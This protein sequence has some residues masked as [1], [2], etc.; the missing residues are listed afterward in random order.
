MIDGARL[1]E[2][3][4]LSSSVETVQQDWDD[5]VGEV[6]A[7]GAIVEEYL[8]GR[9]CSP[10]GQAYIDRAGEVHVLST[11]EQYTVVDQYLGC[12]FP[13]DDCF[14]PGIHGALVKVGRKLA[15]NGVR[16]TFGVDFISL[17][18]GSLLA[19]EINL[20]KV[21]PSHA[22]AYAEA[23]AGRKVGPDG[24][25]RV[26]GEP[27]YFSHRRVHQPQVLRGLSPQAAVQ[28]LV[29]DGLSYDPA[30]GKGTLLHILGALGPLGYV[31]TTCLGRSRREA[32]DASD[33]AF[34]SLVRTATSRG[35]RLGHATADDA[36][37]LH[38]VIDLDQLEP[39]GLP[40][41]RVRRQ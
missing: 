39:E 18:D 34:A 24:N 11:H 1:R 4:D 36:T 9:I 35:R 15:A 7:G 16:G 30:S 8:A 33:A 22:V 28:G 6:G 10:S 25:L 13:A 27:L 40:S 32:A 37:L 12:E 14:R 19:T 3:S 5:I 23:V 17:N 38:P 41:G 21:G 26:N 29:D 2:S 31:E 20:R